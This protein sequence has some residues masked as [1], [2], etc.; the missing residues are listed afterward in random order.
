[1]LPTRGL[2]SEFGVL[3]ECR[4]TL[5]NFS[6]CSTFHLSTFSTS[7]RLTFSPTNLYLQD[8]RALPGHLRSRKFVSSSYTAR[9]VAIF[10]SLSLLRLQR[11]KTK[12]KS[13]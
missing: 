6:L 10:S 7:D 3:I 1:M 5:F 13:M 11:V 9:S 2:M 12:V 4:G 8:E